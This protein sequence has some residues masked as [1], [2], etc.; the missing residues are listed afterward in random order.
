MPN[1]EPARVVVTGV[2]AIT[3]QGATAQELW[4]NVRDCRVAIRPVD[5]LPMDGYMTT[6]GG[7]VQESVAP[8]SE[9]RHPSDYREPVVDFALKAGEEA[10]ANCGI[11]ATEQIPAERWAVVVGSCNAGLLAGEEWYKKGMAG[12]RTP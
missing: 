1:S 6:L 12:A 10:L 2:G 9:Y 11:A 3:S 7:E 4:E 5:H 8:A